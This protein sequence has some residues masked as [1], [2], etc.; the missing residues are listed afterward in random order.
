MRLKAFVVVFYCDRSNNVYLMLL[1]PFNFIQLPLAQWKS[2]FKLTQNK[3]TLKQLLFF[4][5]TSVHCYVVQLNTVARSDHY[6]CGF[7]LSHSLCFHNN[8]F[9]C[10][11]EIKQVG[12]KGVCSP[13][14]FVIVYFAAP[15]FAVHTPE[16]YCGQLTL[17][18]EKKHHRMIS[19]LQDT[20]MDVYILCWNCKQKCK[21]KS[22]LM[23]SNVANAS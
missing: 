2:I 9:V 18:S 1:I 17:Q 23:E 5:T 4:S 6:L 14:L 10:S 11:V 21:L 8:K 7:V 15:D 16:S 22:Y 3:S 19:T 20:L 13:D 12:F